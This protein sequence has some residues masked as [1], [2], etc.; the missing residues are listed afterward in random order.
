MKENPMY[1]VVG[2][3]YADNSEDIVINQEFI[4]CET[5]E[6][7]DEQALALEKQLKNINPNHKIT[8]WI[9]VF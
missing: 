5:Q 9:N 2:T 1:V 8:T 7:A 4:E 3:V 6:Q